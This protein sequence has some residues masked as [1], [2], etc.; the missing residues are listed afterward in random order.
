MDEAETNPRQLPFVRR[1]L[2]ISE[3]T[4]YTECADGELPHS[5]L[6]DPVDLF[7]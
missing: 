7:T 3:G 4:E 6:E 1:T 2:R 5:I